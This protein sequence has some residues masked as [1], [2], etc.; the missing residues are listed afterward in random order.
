MELALRLTPFITV[1]SDMTLDGARRLI[2]GCNGRLCLRR[3][4]ELSLPES[5]WARRYGRCYLSY[6]RS[7]NLPPPTSAHR[8]CALTI[9][10]SLSF[11]PPQV[12]Q[13]YF[14]LPFSSEQQT[15]ATFKISHAAASI[16]FCPDATGPVAFD[17]TGVR[18]SARDSGLYAAGPCDR[19]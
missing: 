11:T 19:I 12:T 16:S 3:V 7:D 18:F 2:A 17:I 13:I 4:K 14:L 9:S 6:R 5:Q 15:R 8:P 1:R 10:C